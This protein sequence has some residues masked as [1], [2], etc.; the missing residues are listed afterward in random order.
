M[1]LDNVVN[2]DDL[3][4]DDLIIN[5]INLNWK[6]LVITLKAIKRSIFIPDKMAL[7]G[8]GRRATMLLVRSLP[9]PQILCSQSF[10]FFSDKASNNKIVSKVGAPKLNIVKR[11]MF[12][13]T[14]ETPNPQSLKFVPGVK[15]SWE[16]RWL[17]KWRNGPSYPSRV[18]WIIKFQRCTDILTRK[19]AI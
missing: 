14:Q 12:I 16:Y 10:S 8:Q 2:W 5:L 7:M 15:V 19:N 3:G 6:R 17:T 13:Q 4:A 11:F 1:F 18:F 9:K